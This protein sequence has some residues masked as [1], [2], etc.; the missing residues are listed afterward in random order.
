MFP[1]TPV[2]A[3]KSYFGNLFAASG[4]VETAAS[5][6][7]IAEGRVP[8]TLELRVPGPGMPAEGDPRR[9][10]VRGQPLALVINRTLAGQAAA[11]VLGPP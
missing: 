3:P 2:T 1:T 11:L 10:A 6:L 9:A 8:P 5:V 4:A 7:A